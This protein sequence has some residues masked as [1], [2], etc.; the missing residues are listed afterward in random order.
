MVLA[1]TEMI[2]TFAQPTATVTVDTFVVTPLDVF[3]H[4]SALY[5]KTMVLQMPK[6]SCELDPIP[7]SLFFHYLYKLLPRTTSIS[8]ISLP[9][10]I[11]PICFKDV[12]TRPLLKKPK[13]YFGNLKIQTSV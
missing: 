4:I 6:K 7:Y 10:G 12:V 3:K 13:L 8:N 1:W 9:S 11:V 5:L 2:H